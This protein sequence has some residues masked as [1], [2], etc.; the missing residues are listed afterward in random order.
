MSDL[1]LAQKPHTLVQA[2]FGLQVVVIRKPLPF[3]MDLS[4]ISC[5]LLVL[6]V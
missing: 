6:V 1:V 4:G 3:E 5:P 2:T